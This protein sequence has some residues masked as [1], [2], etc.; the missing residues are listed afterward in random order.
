MTT[1]PKSEPP[2]PPPITEGH[3]L[4][5]VSPNPSDWNLGFCPYRNR[6]MLLAVVPV[7]LWFI[8]F[9]LELSEVHGI[10]SWLGLASF[11]LIISWYTWYACFVLSPSESWGQVLRLRLA[12]WPRRRT[13]SD[14]YRQ[15][16]DLLAVLPVGLGFC[17]VAALSLL[18]E[19]HLSESMSPA[20]KA[21][22]ID[23]PGAGIACLLMSAGVFGLSI[24]LV[25]RL[26]AI[27]S[28]GEVRCLDCGSRITGDHRT[29]PDRCLECGSRGSRSHEIP[30]PPR[31]KVPRTRSD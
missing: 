4:L 18:G 12:Y 15:Y 21:M 8:G 14:S 26:M 16:F 10:A 2:P 11:A 13:R 30:R 6:M 29:E 27:R 5:E 19:A 20:F 17:S 3:P 23:T 1:P 25:V 9:M 28:R 7:V 22:S 24:I 31:G